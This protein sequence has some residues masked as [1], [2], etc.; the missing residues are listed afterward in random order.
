MAH[1]IR[2]ATWGSDLDRVVEIHLA[3]FPGFF[4]SAMGPRFLRAYYRVL[5]ESTRSILLVIEPEGGGAA[6][7]FVAGVVDPQRFQGELRTHAVALGVAA[8]PTLLRRP[9]LAA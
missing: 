9:Q 1:R 6:E 7:G 4:L 5:R 2:E 8:L 3:A